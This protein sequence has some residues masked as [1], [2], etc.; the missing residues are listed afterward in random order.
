MVIG[1]ACVVDFLTRYVSPPDCVFDIECRA[2]SGS[3]RA[4]IVEQCAI[5]K[6]RVQCIHCR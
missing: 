3:S 6:N 5:K 2:S 4:K 1:S